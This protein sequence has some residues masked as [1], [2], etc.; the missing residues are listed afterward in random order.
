MGLV[1]V[2]WCKSS[3]RGMI[4][5]RTWNDMEISGEAPFDVPLSCFKNSDYR[6]YE[7]CYGCILITV[8]VCAYAV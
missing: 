4:S 1:D 7:M 5:E 2:Y 8:L 3:R 6:A